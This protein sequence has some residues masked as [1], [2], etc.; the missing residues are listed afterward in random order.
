MYTMKRYSMESDEFDSGEPEGDSSS[1]SL[2]SSSFIEVDSESSEDE[3]DDNIDESKPKATTAKAKP[4]VDKDSPARLSAEKE[5][6]E[7]NA[8]ALAASSPQN[9]DKEQLLQQERELNALIYEDARDPVPDEV[10]GPWEFDPR[11]SDGDVSDDEG[12]F[13]DYLE[14]SI[15]PEARVLMDGSSGNGVCMR[16]VGKERG[17][18]SDSYSASSSSSMSFLEEGESESESVNFN[19]KESESES[20]KGIISMV[21]KAGNKLVSKVTSTAASAKNA[22]INSVS[23][24][25]QLPSKVSDYV[26]TRR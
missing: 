22:V 25:P 17:E 1:S 18:K 5:R 4:K 10:P 19:L 13:F 8:K 21:S 7:A 3:A 12:K 26:R 14:Y 16:D 9:L 2:S 20:E 24:I 23:S 6:S 11:F 15:V